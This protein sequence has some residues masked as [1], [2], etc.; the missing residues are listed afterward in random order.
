MKGAIVV[1]ATYW[2]YISTKMTATD[3]MRAM[4]DQL[5]GTSRN[6]KNSIDDFH[7]III[8]SRVLSTST[9]SFIYNKL[10]CKLTN[11]YTIF[12]VASTLVIVNTHHNQH[13]CRNN[14]NQF[15]YKLFWLY[16]EKKKILNFNFAYYFIQTKMSSIMFVV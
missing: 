6:G 2:H 13:L 7:V 15:A 10:H 16:R 3:Q 12:D 11:S 8:L 1:V 14:Q 4:L 9:S 5:M